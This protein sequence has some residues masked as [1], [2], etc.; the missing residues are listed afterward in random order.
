MADVGGGMF[1]VA[2]PSAALQPSTSLTDTLTN[3]GHDQAM[4]E[5]LKMM[6]GIG[7]EH[8][9]QSNAAQANSVGNPSDPATMMTHAP[10]TGMPM[11]TPMLT[12]IEGS[13]SRMF[14]R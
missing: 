2:Q 9:P 12:Q 10:I 5:I 6:T 11:R 8:M 7:D 14:E 3:Q 4:Q 1:G 13:Y